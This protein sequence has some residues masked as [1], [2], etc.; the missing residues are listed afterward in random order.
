MRNTDEFFDSVDDVFDMNDDGYQTDPEETEEEE[1][2]EMNDDTQEDSS[3]DES[4]PEDSEVDDDSD[5]DADEEDGAEGDGEGDSD[6]DAAQT[7]TI[8]VNKEE[9]TVTLEEMT[10]LAQKG[11]DYDRVKDQNSRHQQTITDL[12]SQLDARQ[13]VM[14][15]L[16][17]IAQKS[18]STLEQLAESLYINFRKSAGASEEVAREELKN[19]K[20]EKELN[21]YKTQQTKQ[22][23]QEND[24]EA[25][26]QR[27]LEE[28]NRDYPDVALT[29][30]LVEKLIP[31]IQ[32]G[33]TLSAAYR[34]Y[35]KAQDSARIAELERQLAAKAQNKKNRAK[36]T[37]SKRDSGAGNAPDLSDIFEKELFR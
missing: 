28:F 25:R 13:G 19:A 22:Q 11:A 18:G 15:I 30:E 3:D 26:A 17:N 31:D 10:T 16:D 6:T 35:E 20:L 8:K 12:Q 1:A 4:D 36:A 37:G 7:F 21:T 9:R 14:D 33:M 2:E 27:D 5:T 29:E 24:A 34:K 23:E 32:K